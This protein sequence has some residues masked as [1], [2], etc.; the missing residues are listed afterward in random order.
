MM[1]KL[2][3][4]YKFVTH[5]LLH[6][7]TNTQYGIIW[8]ERSDCLYRLDYVLIGADEKLYCHHNSRNIERLNRRPAFCYCYMPWTDDGPMMRAG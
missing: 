7:S 4:I 2:Q 3:E 6:L 1:I 8:R 5:D